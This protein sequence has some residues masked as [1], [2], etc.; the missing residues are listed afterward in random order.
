MSL[1]QTIVLAAR[2]ELLLFSAVGFALGGIDDLMVDAVWITRRLWRRLT[3]Y[4]IH[5][6]ATAAALPLSR[7]R[8]KIAVFIPAWREDAVIEEMLRRTLRVWEGDAYRLYVGC[9]IND[10]E[11]IAAARRVSDQRIRVVIGTTPG[12]TTKAACLNVLHRA[13]LEDERLANKLYAA[14]LLHDAEDS[15][16]P[17]ELRVHAALGE[18]FAFIQTPVLPLRCPNS[19]WVS[20]HY[21]DEFAEAHS[22]DMVVREA[23]G[24]ALPS[25]G[26]GC[27][28]RRDALTLIAD[29]RGGDPFA[30]DSLTEDYELGL[31]LGELDLPAAF[32]RIQGRDGHIVATRAEFPTTLAAAVRQKTRWTIGIALAGWDRVGWMGG[33]MERWMRLRDRR[34]P[35]AAL[36]LATGYLALILTVAVILL[37]DQGT[38]P[39][40]MV[41]W[42]LTVNGAFLLWRLLVRA[43]C[44]THHYGWREGIRS[45][46]RM[47][48]SNIVAIMAARRAIGTYLK[49]LRT[50]EVHWDKTDHSFPNKAAK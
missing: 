3:V 16:H 46:P 44:V 20:G 4:S 25:A 43:T 17:D 7:A 49:M 21:L 8:G 12:P 39:G 5:P 2:D 1:F 48:T 14:A 18:R 33:A 10:P 27:S 32:V 19:P 47:I 22:R 30:E 9:Y 13:M 41:I 34:A 11:T 26:V 45:V 29:H 35:I 6:R 50:G 31:R 28:I 42:L 24:A 15:V 40:P 36:L 23:V 38:A 37:G